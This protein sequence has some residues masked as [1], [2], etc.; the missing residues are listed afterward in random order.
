MG[1]RDDLKEKISENNLT[2]EEIEKNTGVS[3]K[4]L[5]SY[6]LNGGELK[7][8]EF[9]KISDFVN[10]EAFRKHEG[11]A[12]QSGTHNVNI[13]VVHVGGDGEKIIEAVSNLVTQN[14]PFK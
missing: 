9:E 13:Q 4:R 6:L 14:K 2:L 11:Y 12:V 3:R 5:E 8:E 10:L 1:L 7:I